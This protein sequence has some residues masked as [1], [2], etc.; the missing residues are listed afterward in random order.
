M[1]FFRSMHQLNKESKALRKDWDPVA[2]TRQG[3]RMMQAATAQLAEQNAAAHLAETG[4]PG[5]ATILAVRDT[6]TRIDF[7][8]LVELDLL[9]TVTGRPP[10]PLT[11]S[12]VVPVVGQ[13]RL[14]PGG[15]V[16]VRVDPA[17][18]G[19]AAVMWAENPYG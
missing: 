18:P 10:Y 17:Q 11:L 2:Q 16:S 14:T 19:Q 13:G 9:V 12:T 6:G 15:T 5:T 1:G 7:Q 8:P 4:L 3:L